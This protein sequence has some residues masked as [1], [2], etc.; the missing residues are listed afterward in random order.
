MD[1]FA[2]YDIAARRIR[3]LP[4]QSPTQAK[5][6][7][8]IYHQATNFLHLHMLPL[9]SLPKVLKHAT[10]HG[11][12]LPHN[13]NASI[14]NGGTSALAAIKYGNQEGANST[15]SLASDNSSA[16]SALE[17]E[18]KS[19]RER[20]IVL[21]EQKFFVTEMIAD[22]NRRRKYDEASSLAQNAEDLSKEIDRV[23]GMI[24][25]LDFEGLYSGQLCVK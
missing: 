23:N 1:S 20:L 18:E 22:A 21:E 14:T 19:L 17:T 2:Q 4:T 25:Q 7:K 16:I 24:G 15:T 5:L 8:A 6:Q 12:K 3:D 9:K 10:P 11:N 13:I